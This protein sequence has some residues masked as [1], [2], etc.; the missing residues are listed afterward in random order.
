MGDFRRENHPEFSYLPLHINAI[1]MFDQLVQLVKQHAGD[2]IINNPAIPN[3]Y[4][5][6]AIN[7]VASSIF[8]GLQQHAANGNLQDIVT[9]F[10][11]G[12]SG[13]F[14]NHPIVSNIISSAAGTLTTKY[15]V[16][17]QSAQSIIS[18]LMPTVM[19]QFIS[20][21]NNPNDNSFNL[22]N[23]LQTVS[24]NSNLNVSNLLGQVTG[25]NS[26]NLFGSLSNLAGKLFG[27]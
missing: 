5:D 18:Q 1:P 14:S 16:S 12:G 19:N 6:S 7:D 9:L 17:S 15:G 21:T 25:G 26:N 23:I 22:T 24:G 8:N 20:R 2:A 3:Q 11:N 27:N 13:S 4:N 10:Q